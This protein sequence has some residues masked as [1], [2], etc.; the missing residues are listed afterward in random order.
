MFQYYNANPQKKKVDDC[1]VRAI[2]LATNCSWDKAY[3]EL[4]EFARAQCTMPNDVLYMDDYL[5]RHFEKVCGCRDKKRI[6][7]SDFLKQHNIGVYL[8]TM[9]GHITCAIDGIIYDIFD[10]SNNYIWDAYRVDKRED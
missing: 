5:E 3:I 9:K 4:S 7:V 10:P 2:S 8:I 1:T 6:T